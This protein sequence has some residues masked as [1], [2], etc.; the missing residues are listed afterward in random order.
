MIELLR[1]TRKEKIEIIIIEFPWGFFSVKLLSR[2]KRII[3]YDS[4]GVESEFIEITALHPKF[5]KI[6]KPFARFYTKLYEMLVCKLANVVISV[7]NV[8]REYYIKN[9]GINRGKTILIQT[10]SSIIVQDFER[11]EEIKK[12]SRTKLGLPINKTIVIFHGVLPH[13][14]N[15]EAFNLIENYIAPNINNPDILFVFAGTNVE[16]FESNNIK[17]L[18][19]VEDLKDL[20]FSADFAIVPIISGSGMRVK[21]AD[22]I[23]ANLPFITTDKGIEGLDFLERGE[24][25]LGFKEVNEDFIEGINFLSKNKELQQQ[26]QE[27]LLR[28]SKKISKKKFENRYIKLL[29]TIKK[30]GN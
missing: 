24:D 8:D 26:F 9:Y 15:Q 27:N 30:D 28:N 19:F 16:E 17:S 21:C 11:T 6:L 2:K 23:S 4:A 5:P 25:Y 1:I 10:P 29:T 20:L 13:P 3:L 12:K 7:S 22:Y 14:P 18:G